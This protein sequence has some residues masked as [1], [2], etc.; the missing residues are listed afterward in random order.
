MQRG[1]EFK[2]FA[3]KVVS[4][5][6]C[7]IHFHMLCQSPSH[8]YGNVQ[9]KPLYFMQWLFGILHSDSNVEHRH[10]FRSPVKS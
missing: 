5:M 1:K 4:T 10:H 3:D 9:F 2:H 8:L 7:D 6:L